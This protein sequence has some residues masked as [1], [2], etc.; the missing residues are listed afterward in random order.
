MKK[1]DKSITKPVDVP[2]VPNASQD[3]AGSTGNKRRILDNGE[4]IVLNSDSDSDSDEL[5]ILEFD[6]LKK[7][8]S[9]TTA[10]SASKPRIASTGISALSRRAKDDELRKPPNRSASKTETLSALVQ[11]AKENTEMENRIAAGKAT[12]N[13]D[14]E[15]DSPKPSGG[16]SLDEVILA[17]GGKDE[18]ER[19][20]A[21]RVLTAIQRTNVGHTDYVFYF[22][23]E[24]TVSNQH[25]PV[26]FPAT[27]LPSHGWVTNLEDP[28]QR[29]MAF[30]SGFAK[31]VFQYQEFPEELALWVIDQI[32]LDQTSGLKDIYIDILEA[33]HHHLEKLIDI[34]MIERMFRSMGT[35]MQG[36][37]LLQEVIASEKPYKSPNRRLPSSLK[38]VTRLLRVAAKWLVPKVAS[39]ALLVLVHLCFDD[40]VMGDASTLIDVQETVEVIIGSISDLAPIL[41]DLVPGLVPR[42]TNPILQQNL[43]LS[44]P[45]KSPLTASLQR[46]LAL[47]FLLH[48]APLKVSLD[49]PRIL[50]MIHDLLQR[51]PHFIIKSKRDTNYTAF[52]ARMVLLD[53]GIGPGLGGV[54]YPRPVVPDNDDSE[55]PL[56]PKFRG[57]TAEEISFNKEVDDLA[58]HVKIVGNQIIETGALSDLTILQAKE[59]NEKLFHRLENSVRIGGP[60]KRDPF[61][62]DDE[63]PTQASKNIFL[64]YLKPVQS[65]SKSPKMDA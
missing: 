36:L 24:N 50:E 5:E 43:I 38:W 20:R 39:H 48:P 62:D 29:D 56:F 59:T 57:F 13:L 25:R 10:R 2:G 21:K 65:P 1:S 9:A 26:S 33:H 14:L 28:K 18:A 54:P 11:L 16:I 23:D 32:Y 49:D 64:K 19:E 30:S 58:R 8:P 40:S 55:T 44:L 31:F 4:P 47:A 53:I 51:S 27:K 6:F 35:N 61:G 37:N 46:H 34:D 45:T 60:K 7:A 52:A 3:S 15:E 41:N 63:K 22:F 17:G 42:I 12:L